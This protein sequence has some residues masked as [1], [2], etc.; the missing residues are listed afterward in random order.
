MLPNFYFFYASNMKNVLYA[1]LSGVL[2]KRSKSLESATEVEK[3]GFISL[4]GM[5]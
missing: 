1:G 2:R 5:V 4:S 3:P